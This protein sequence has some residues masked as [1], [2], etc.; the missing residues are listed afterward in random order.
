M[1]TSTFDALFTT[2]HKFY[3]YMDRFVNIPG[4]TGNQGLIDAALKN[5]TK[6][7]SGNLHA[8]LHYFMYSNPFSGVDAPIGIELDLV[9]AV[10][11]AE[12]AKLVVGASGFLHM[13]SSADAAADD[14]ETGLC[15]VGPQ[16]EVVRI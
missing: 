10:P 11:V 2:G 9:Y 3:G 13:G 8:A 5:D 6:V 4:S 12:M 1:V 16:F 15:Y 7:G 14:I